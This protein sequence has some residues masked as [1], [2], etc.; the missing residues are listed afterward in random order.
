MVKENNHYRQVVKIT[1]E[2]FDPQKLNVYNLYISYSR[3][4]VRLAVLD[5]E[6]NKFI[7]LEDYKVSHIF[8]PLQ[9]AQVF[10]EFFSGHPYVFNPD[11]HQIK[12]AVNNHNYTFIPDTLF[13][14]EAAADYL[15]LNCDF[16][17]DHEKIFTYKHTGIEAV[18][19][20]SVDKYLTQI[21]D[22]QLPQKPI[23]YLHLTC[24]LIARL[25]QF[26]ERT[27]EKRLYAYVQDKSL[28]L[29]VI[30]EGKMEFCNLFQCTTPED[31]LYFLIL[32][33]QEQKLNP[34][35]DR[36]TIWGDLTHDSSLFTLLRT[37]IRNVQFGSRPP[38]VSYSYKI[39]DLFQHQ[40]LDVFGIHFCE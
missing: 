1:D 24:P 14:K 20:F 21:W 26:G 18:N 38:G 17:S 28:C 6:R 32:V 22:R 29:L 27:A 10:N 5:T 2:S 12:L 19:I 37:Y 40:Y 4:R 16:D 7:S 30:Q 39:E 25:L 13:E 36:V 31:F 34:D 35:Q 15:R 11:W 9:G 23:N 3:D 33:T 8:T